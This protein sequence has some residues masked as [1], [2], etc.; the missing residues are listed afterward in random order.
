MYGLRKIRNP[1]A[2]RG[3]RT[4]AFRAFFPVTGSISAFT[5]LECVMAV[6]IGAIM[7]TSLYAGFT[8]GIRTMGVARQDLRATEILLQRLERV[9][10][11]S[12][13]QVTDTSINPATS[14]EYYNPAAPTNGVPYTI[15][16]SATVPV[17]NSLPEA[18]RTNMLL[19]TVSASW[20]NG[21]QGHT[22]SMQTY[23]AQNGM[24]SYV[25]TGGR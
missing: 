16:F 22:R 19:V 9:R 3:E 21:T 18:Y 24:Q 10:L 15:T 23:V 11:C 13:A 5:L 14:T 2:S 4:T 17:T 8:Q 7:F 20:T 1:A 6:G 25:A 12:Y